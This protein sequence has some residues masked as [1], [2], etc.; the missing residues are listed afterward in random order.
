LASGSMLPGLASK[1]RHHDSGWPLPRLCV[2]SRSGAARCKQLTSPS[3]LPWQNHASDGRSGVANGPSDEGPRAAPMVM[4]A[5]SVWEASSPRD[6]GS[7]EQVLIVRFRRSPA[8]SN[9]EVPL[10]PRSRA[11]M[12]RTWPPLF[13]STRLHPLD[14]GGRRR[15]RRQPPG[16]SGQ[17]RIFRFES[18]P[19]PRCKQQSRGRFYV[20]KVRRSAGPEPARAC[21]SCPGPTS[22]SSADVSSLCSEEQCLG[23]TVEH[24]LTAAGI[25]GAAGLDS[26][27]PSERG[28]E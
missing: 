18:F 4:H 2:E 19:Q 24:P 25:T 7:C 11:S 9:G 3:R 20:A 5:S 27:G 22:R 15:E 10:A 17:A 28:H 8:R 13:E 6:L 21:Q 12:E 16:P 26:F 14:L 23:A 1:E